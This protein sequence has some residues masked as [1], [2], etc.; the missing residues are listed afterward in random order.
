MR[1]VKHLKH[2]MRKEVI[3]SRERVKDIE[4]ILVKRFERWNPCRALE[5]RPKAP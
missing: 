3:A 4:L 5:T 2:M 1:I